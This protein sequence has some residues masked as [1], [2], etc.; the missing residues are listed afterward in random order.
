MPDYGLRVKTPIGEIQIDSLYRNLSLDQEG[1][2]LITNGNTATT[3]YTE[4]PISALSLPPL[5]LIQPAIN[6]FTVVHSY[7]TSLG[8]YVAFRVVTEASSS[9]T[10]N[11][12]CCRETPAVSGES[13]GMRVYN[14]GGNLVFDSGKKYFKIKEVHTFNVVTYVD[15]LH[16]NFLDPFYILNPGSFAFDCTVDPISYI[17][18]YSMIGLKKLTA[19]SVRVGWFTFG[20]ERSDVDALSSRYNPTQKLIVCGL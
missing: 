12:K 7:I 8:N 1:T 2:S 5:I 4:I 20:G 10:I 14:P 18:V 13:Y 19:T 16:P 9:T 15:I 11:W 6:Y 3:Y 17:Y